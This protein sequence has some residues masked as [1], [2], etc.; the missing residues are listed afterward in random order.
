MG[1]ST[2]G[3]PPL[4]SYGGTASNYFCVFVA[5]VKSTSCLFFHIWFCVFSFIPAIRT[6]F[7]SFLGFHFSLCIVGQCLSV[8]TSYHSADLF[9]DIKQTDHG[10]AASEFAK[11]LGCGPSFGVAPPL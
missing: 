4:F 11:W 10:M 8:Y 6:T 3:S 2:I 1:A 9:G 5:I 7:F